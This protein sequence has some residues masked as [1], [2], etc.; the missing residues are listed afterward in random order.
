MKSK[1]LFKDKTKILQL[2]TLQTSFTF[3]NLSKHLDVIENY[4]FLNFFYI[5]YQYSLFDIVDFLKIENID[6]SYFEQISKV[7]DND[8]NKHWELYNEIINFIKKEKLVYNDFMF[9]K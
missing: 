1:E 8:S 4:K 5:F 7:E 2:L 3:L 6:K 9:Q